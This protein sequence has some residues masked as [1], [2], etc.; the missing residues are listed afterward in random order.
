MIV[1]LFDREHVH[2]AMST[3]VAMRPVGHKSEGH[4]K[5]YCGRVLKLEAWRLFDYAAL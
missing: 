4:W 2:K 1:L 3:A 5:S